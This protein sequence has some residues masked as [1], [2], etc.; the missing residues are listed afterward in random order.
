MKIERMEGTDAESVLSIYG[1]GIATRMATFETNL[2]DWAQWDANHLPAP[3]LVARADDGRV[4]GWA[5]LS[6]VSARA[7]YSGV[8]EVS[9]YIAEPFRGQGI[10]TAL[11]AELIEKAEAMGFWTLQ[12][13]IF[14]E[15]LAS[16]KLH[17]TFGF[18]IVGR[19][20][21][22]AQLDGLWR[23]T[24]LLERRSTIH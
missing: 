11:M 14:P 18:R 15:N 5:A 4:A 20:E 17:E 13:S 3:R 24:V 19:R 2:P 8:A 6:R 23:D 10:G 1:E 22:I 7:C 9:V 12:S 21:R 16:I